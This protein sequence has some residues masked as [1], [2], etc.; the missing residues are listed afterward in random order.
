MIFN[1]HLSQMQET[2][3]VN[4]LMQEF[5]I[6]GYGNAD[7]KNIGDI[8]V[9]GYENVAFPFITLLIGFCVAFFQLGI[10]IIILMCCKSCNRA[11]AE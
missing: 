9:L 7:S 8:I 6:K 3:V 5:V 1:Y 11:R 10:E 2:G 4:R